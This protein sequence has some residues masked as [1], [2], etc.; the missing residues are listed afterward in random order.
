MPRRSILSAAERESLLELPDTQDELIR[1]YTFSEPDLSLIRQRRGEANRLGV[2]VQLCLLRFPGQGLLPDAAVP[3]S[4]L[5]W[6]GRQLRLDPACWPQ[7]AEREETR[8]EHLLELRAY[9]GMEPF[10]L[11]HY[12]QAVHA[13][14]ELALQ[15]D[16]GIVLA[17]SVLESLR[18]EHIILP[19]LDV[20]ERVL[21]EAI[22]RA[23]RRI[24]DALA[25]PLT[26]AHRRRLDDLLKR[27]DNGKTTW[28]AWL[29]QSPVKPNSRHMLEHIERLKAWQALDL[30]SGIERLVHQNRL[31]KIAREGGQMTPADLAKFEAQRRY[32]TLVALAIEGMA[33][34]TD[35]IIDLHDRILG[36]LF[37]AAKNKH[38]QQFQASGKAIN[39]KVR[40]ATSIKQGT[41]TASLMLRKLGS[42]PRQNGLA[43]ALRE[44]GR[45]ERTL[46]I[47]DWLQSVELRRRVH[48]G[49]NKGEARNALARA[50]FFN[51]LGEIRD[52]SFEQQRYRASGLNLVTAAIVLWNTVYLERAS[53]ALRGHGQTVDDALLQYLSPLGWEHINLTGDYLWRSSA[54]IGAGKFR[55][56]RPL[57]PA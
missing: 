46:F 10:G 31:L 25:E 21:A 5:Q 15:T 9:L 30:P 49:L 52:R 36:K 2:A 39:A 19:A 57:Q 28:L 6:I 50:V 18:H 8:R 44:L 27:R 7:Y 29:R 26:G 34:V 22:T 41:V 3:M 1:H 54:K 37:N 45:I 14:T 33:T 40:L 11:A 13:T 16:K 12:R 51:R 32:A 42:Y 20:V 24:Y 55:P 35:E 48:A 17:S 47:L 4:L 23:N 56:L 53:N 43:V 38:Q